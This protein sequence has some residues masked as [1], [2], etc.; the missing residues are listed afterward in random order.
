MRSTYSK[1]KLRDENT[2]KTYLNVL[3]ANSACSKLVLIL[4]NY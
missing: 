1:N 3:R 4:Y 2:S